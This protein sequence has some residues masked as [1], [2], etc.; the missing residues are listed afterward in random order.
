MGKGKI[1][2]TLLETSTASK[3]EENFGGY[4]YPRAGKKW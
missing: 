3:S 1:R 4:F 2:I